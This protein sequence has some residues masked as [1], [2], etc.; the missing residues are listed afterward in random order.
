MT[1]LIDR[2]T[3]QSEQILA[4]QIKHA[5]SHATPNDITECIDCGE[6]I[7][8]VRKQALPHAVRCVGCQWTHER[9]DETGDRR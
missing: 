2:A 9:T 8:K 3:T 7:G 4:M 5:Q 6:P 1:D